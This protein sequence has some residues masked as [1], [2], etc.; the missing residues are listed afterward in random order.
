VLI[1][2]IT[3]HNGL[4]LTRDGDQLRD[5]QGNAFPIVAGGFVAVTPLN[6]D[7]IHE[8]SL[9]PLAERFM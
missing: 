3:P 6:F 4:P 5:D 1:E 8:D 9:G 7:L 2:F